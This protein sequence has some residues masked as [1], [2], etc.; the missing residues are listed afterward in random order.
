M[1]T[2]IKMS[3]KNLVAEVFISSLWV[4][5]AHLLHSTQSIFLYRWKCYICLDTAAAYVCPAQKQ[6]SVIQ[7]LDSFWILAHH[8][9]CI[10]V[11][12]THML[13]LCY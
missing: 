12:I 7:A 4:W 8:K 3:V 1:Q 2:Y 5:Y 9:E 6:R 10:L 13:Y 11:R